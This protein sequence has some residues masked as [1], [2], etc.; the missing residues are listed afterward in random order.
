MS[1]SRSL[2]TS[3]PAGNNLTFKSK[4]LSYPQGITKNRAKSFH[5]LK[6]THRFWRRAED[7]EVS[8]RLLAR[9]FHPFLLRRP[10]WDRWSRFRILHCD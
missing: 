6:T 1:L 4:T 8:P 3:N 5:E 2:K 10:S 9:L 7:S